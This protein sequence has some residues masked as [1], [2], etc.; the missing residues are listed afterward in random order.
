MQVTS[1]DFDLFYIALSV[2]IVNY[3]YERY[4]QVDDL[5]KQIKNIQVYTCDKRSKMDY[6]KVQ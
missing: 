4:L 5:H 6:E 1:F 3:I 2:V